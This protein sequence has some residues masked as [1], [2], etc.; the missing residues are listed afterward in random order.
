MTAKKVVVDGNDDVVD[1]DEILPE[2]TPTFEIEGRLVRVK[3]LKARE[4][5]GLVRVLTRGLGPN[6]GMLAGIDWDDQ[7][8]AIQ[9]LLGV[10][11]VAIPNALEEFIDF[12]QTVVEPVHESDRGVVFAELA[13][14]EIDVVFSVF[15][16][17]AIQEMDDLKGLLG[18]AKGAVAVI[19][20][21]HKARG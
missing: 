21:A 20:S 14:P 9:Q 12:I 1:L 15:E 13:N 17:V 8:G 10:A 7:S 11:V 16:R 4:F 19:A 6:V 18:K 5:L 3:R 2:I